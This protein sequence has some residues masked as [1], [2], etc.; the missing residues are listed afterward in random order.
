MSYTYLWHF[1]DI[2][3]IIIIIHYESRLVVN[4]VTTYY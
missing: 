1:H 3:N 4:I 2:S